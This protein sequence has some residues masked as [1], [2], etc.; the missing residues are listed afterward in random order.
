MT[1]QEKNLEDG[2]K[3][4]ESKNILTYVLISLISFVHSRQ[5]RSG[6][7]VTLHCFFQ[8]FFG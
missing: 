6:I 8:I 3:G 5:L 4:I 7:D 2:E 1:T